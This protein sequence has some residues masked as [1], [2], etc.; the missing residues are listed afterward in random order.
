MAFQR[1]ASENSRPSSLPARLAFRTQKAAFRFRVDERH[2]K[3]NGF[4]L[5]VHV[6]PC[7]FPDRVFLKHKSLNNDRLVTVLG[8]GQSRSQSAIPSGNP[9]ERG[10]GRNVDG[11][12]LM[13][14]QSDPSV[15]KFRR[16]GVD[17]T[18]R[19]RRS[20]RH[21][22]LSNGNRTERSAV[23]FVIIRVITNYRPN[24]SVYTPVTTALNVI[25]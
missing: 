17:G 3:N 8:R 4:T 14:F 12:H 10:Y 18:L 24:A 20:I 2:L 21:R 23:Q 9:G 1:V 19:A 16:C 11:K 6:P 25:G 7:D 15:F 22:A 5:I 13:R